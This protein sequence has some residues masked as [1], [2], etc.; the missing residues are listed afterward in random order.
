MSDMKDVITALNQ[1][2]LTV[3]ELV[4]LVKGIMETQESMSTVLQQQTE[5]IGKMQAR[6]D[7]LQRER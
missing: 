5:L 6:I 3:Q 1:N 7:S 4:K 2:T